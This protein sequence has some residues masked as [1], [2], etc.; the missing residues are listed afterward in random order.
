MCAKCLHVLRIQQSSVS[1]RHPSAY[2]LCD[3]SSATNLYQ[4]AHCRPPLNILLFDDSLSG[5]VVVR[6]PWG[7]RI[8]NFAW[9]MCSYAHN[10]MLMW[11][12]IPCPDTY[13]NYSSHLTD[14]AQVGQAS[15]IAFKPLSLCL[16]ERQRALVT[17]A[18]YQQPNMRQ[19]L[20]QQIRHSWVSLK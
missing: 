1:M 6:I 9:C 17:K 4:R 13:S 19:E 8:L 20:L 16:L 12:S 3:T 11:L 10:L 5:K 15:F 7:S 2:P 18:T 14:G